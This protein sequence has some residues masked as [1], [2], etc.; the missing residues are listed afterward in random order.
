MK[1][2]EEEET[3]RGDQTRPDQTLSDPW[4]QRKSAAQHKV[5]SRLSKQASTSRDCWWTRAADW[6]AGPLVPAC[7]CKVR[8]GC[9][10]A[11]EKRPDSCISGCSG[12]W[13]VPVP[14][15]HTCTRARTRTHCAALARHCTSAHLQRTA[16]S[17][18]TSLYP[19][20]TPPRAPPPSKPALVL[21]I[22]DVRAEKNVVLTSHNGLRFYTSHRKT[23]SKSISASAWHYQARETFHP[24]EAPST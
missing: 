8:P 2:W 6:L 24:Q 17:R 1:R 5:A 14:A 4:T 11:T 12:H 15:P 20:F 13:E 9:A 7:A 23:Q 21:D 18:S 3:K 19:I 16:L 22:Q 10:E